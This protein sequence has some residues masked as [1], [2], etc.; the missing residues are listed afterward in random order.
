[1]NSRGYRIT[2]DSK[3][4]E[5]T[6]YH[7]AASRGLVKFV[8]VLL[9]ERESHQLNV[10]CP[11]KDGITP[12]YLAKIFGNRVSGGYY[13]PWEHVIQVIESYGGEMLYPT[14]EAEYNVIYSRLYGW[15]PKDFTF[16]L[17]PSVHRFLTSLLTLYEKGENSSFLCTFQNYDFGLDMT[18][19]LQS[20]QEEITEALKV[21]MRR[22]DDRLLDMKDLL[23]RDMMR[24]SRKLNDFLQYFS[25]F[26]FPTLTYPQNILSTRKWKTVH[27]NHR[28]RFKREL[29]FLFRLRHKELFGSFFCFKSLYL[30]FKPF[31]HTEKLKILIR[32]YEKR[33]PS[34]YFTLPCEELR[35]LLF[36]DYL[37][38]YRQR[39][40][41][42]SELLLSGKK[43]ISHPHFISERMKAV[44]KGERSTT[45]LFAV[46]DDEWPLEF[47]L[48]QFLGLFQRY[49]YLKTLHVGIDQ[50]THVRLH[51]D[52]MRQILE[53][54]K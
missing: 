15:I 38:H 32:Q 54:Q 29:R 13:N 22:N 34:F 28:N 16:D 6:L 41:K 14:K 43:Y 5:L 1:M 53:K 44:S 27:R 18:L 50:S 25:S 20:I 12:M 7:L 2:C 23:L 8:E 46:F 26:R 33:P 9:K 11:N 35:R 21:Q 30:R 49:D 51:A 52:K 24:C 31:L 40:R 45:P 47:L 48:N 42:L 19:S 39:K 4:P 37:S 17:K 36:E 3:R 10:N